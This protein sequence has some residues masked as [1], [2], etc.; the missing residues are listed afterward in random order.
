MHA[1]AI[2]YVFTHARKCMCSCARG[3]CGLGVCRAC[4]CSAAEA[5]TGVDTEAHASVEGLLPKPAFAT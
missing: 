3:R 4:L 2:T 1:W 5:T